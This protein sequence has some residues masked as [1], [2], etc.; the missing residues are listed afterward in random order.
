MALPA[1]K[2]QEVLTVLS[3]IIAKSLQPVAAQKE[4]G[5]EHA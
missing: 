1:P 3:Q 5:Y 4:A 2:R